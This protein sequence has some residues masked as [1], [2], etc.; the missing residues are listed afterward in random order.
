MK[1]VFRVD[2]SLEMGAGHVMRCLTLADELSRRGFGCVFVSRKQ[3]GDLINTVKARGYVVHELPTCD[4]PADSHL[5]H[6]HWLKGGWERDARESEAVLKK[7]APDWL[8]VDHYGIDKNW[9][10]QVRACVKDLLVIDDLADREHDG[11]VLLDQNLGQTD[12][13][14]HP[15]VPA[16]CR[17]LTG[18]HYALLRPEFAEYRGRSLEYRK[19][20]TQIDRVLVTMGGVDKDNYS[21]RIL[22]ALQKSNLKQL[23]RVTVVLGQQSPWFNEVRQQADKSVLNVD[24]LQ[25]VSNMAELMS[26]SDLAIGAAGSTSWERCCLGVPTINFVIADNQ[27]EASRQ[28]VKAGAA[29]S[30]EGEDTFEA[31]LISSL[32]YL[33]ANVD[34]LHALSDCSA[35]LVDGVGVHRLCDVISKQN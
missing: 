1:A 28:L 7:L 5:A 12:E 11:N 32:H 21:G 14:Y 24:V 16:D 29:L 4:T 2:A 19:G 31:S 15:L 17:I 22:S 9:E 23:C 10:Q 20:K 3:P 18:C 13:M 34:A 30:I 26:H 35:Q 25:G 27:R 33:C 8:V 6:S